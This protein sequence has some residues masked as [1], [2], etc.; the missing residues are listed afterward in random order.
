MRTIYL[1]IELKEKDRYTTWEYNLYLYYNS[2]QECI[3]SYSRY[4]HNYRNPFILEIESN[5][6]TLQWFDP[7]KQEFTVM[8]IYDVNRYK[9]LI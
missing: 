7:R 5:D 3:D 1:L 2:F 6:F 9:I 8:G 4:F